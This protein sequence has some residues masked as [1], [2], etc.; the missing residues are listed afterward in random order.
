[1]T[2][3]TASEPQVFPMRRECPFAPPTE[4][5]GLRAE[6]PVSRVSLPTG[7]SAW[8]V[9][10]HADVRTVLTDPRFSA[11]VRKP[12]FPLVAPLQQTVGR[13]R[14]SFL[15]MDPP[16]HSAYR[17]MLIAEFTVKRVKALRPG[18]QSTVDG[19]IDAMLAGP[20]HADL[21]E[22]LAL[23]VPSLVICQLLG[24]PYADHESFQDWARVL[25]SRTSG[26]EAVNAVFQQ[27]VGYFDELIDLKRREPGEDLLTKLVTDYLETGQVS[28]ENLV[29]TMILLLNAG[30]ETT[31]NMISLGTVALLENPDQLAELRADPDVLPAAVEELLR[32]LSIADTVPSR[33][34]TED[35]ELGG[36]LIRKGE[37][38]IGLLAAADWDPEV[39]PDAESFDIHRGNRRHLA[40]G[41]GVHQCLGQNLARLELEIV[42]G[43]L[44]ERIP[45]LRVAAPLDELPYKHDSLL[46]GLH[47][48]PVTW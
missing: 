30:H 35:V 39:F 41:Y 29:T 40:F 38:V 12:G 8:V 13:E 43:T 32:Y 23:P 9:T 15:R 2:Q 25:L 44:F 31:S 5:A 7:G 22:S 14:P 11:D 18:I 27:L 10:R 37:G 34:A 1:M 6:R 20:P 46:F 17:R 16:E 36:T 3:S 21:V 24:V 45:T 4:Y 28:R 42:F 33:V 26:H 47:E 19:L 48:L